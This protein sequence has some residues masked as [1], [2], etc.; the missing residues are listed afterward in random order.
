MAKTLLIN[1]D[2]MWLKG[3]NRHLYEKA[4]NAHLKSV[5]A[6]NHKESFS[7]QNERQRQVARSQTDFSIETIERLQKIPGIHGIIP[8]LQIDIDDKNIFST[9]KEVIDDLEKEEFTFKVHTRRSNKKYPITSME[10]SRQLGSEILDHYPKLKVDVKNPEVVIDI[11]IVEDSIYVSSKMYK[12]MGGFPVG[13]SGKVVTLLSGGLDSPVAS[14]LMSKRGCEQSFIFFYA[15]PFVGD[16]VKEKILELSRLIGEFQRRPKIYIVPFGDI[17]KLITKD[18]RPAYRTLIFRKYMIDCANIL[19]DR[20]KAD[21]LCTGDSLGQVSSQTIY[22]IS[23]IDNITQKS[24]FRPLLAFNKSEVIE[25]A[26][27]IGT[28]E[29]SIIPHDDACA[30]FAPKHPIIRPDT[31]YLK[32]FFAEND[33]TK[34][35]GECLDNSEVYTIDSSNKIQLL[36]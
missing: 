27:Q 19:A 32:S 5:L 22:N 15:Y 9:V 12:G 31:Y 2:E 1:T 36:S 14:Y 7:C 29:T 16:E 18:C 4:L 13:T 17:Q 34:E 20:I 30:L 33:L 28:F 35:L 21:A 3:K 11:R 24:I 23:A 25:L 8:V 6:L 26:K 10:L